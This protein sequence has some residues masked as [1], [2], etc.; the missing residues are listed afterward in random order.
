MSFDYDK[1]SK[2]ILEIH[3]IFFS[4]LSQ[5][6]KFQPQNGIQMPGRLLF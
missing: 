2:F 5:I 6:L 4:K 1:H 3:V